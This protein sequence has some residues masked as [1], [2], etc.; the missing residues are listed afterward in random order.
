[1]RG[2]EEREPGTHCSRMR[3]VPLVTCI[4][5]RYT[6]ITVNFCLPAERPHCI[7]ITLPVVRPGH[8][9]LRCLINHLKTSNHRRGL[10]N[11]EA[12]SDIMW[13]HCF[14][15]RLSMML[16][17]RKANPDIVLTSDASS[18]WGCGAF[19]NTLWFQFE[20]SEVLSSLH[21]TNSS[22]CGCMGAPMAKQISLCR[23]CCSPH[24]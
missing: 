18:H 16:D 13:W 9:F 24:D 5:L 11:K 17:D 14:I 12:R 22:S 21:I 2:E 10:L 20:W 15:A 19:W 8:T 6:K 23:C 4:L 3:Q 1:M 7:V